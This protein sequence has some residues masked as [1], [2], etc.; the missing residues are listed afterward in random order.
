MKKTQSFIFC[1]FLSL[2][3]FTACT[4]SANQ[5]QK[6]NKS[7]GL[8]LQSLSNKT[9]LVQVSMCHPAFLK[10]IKNKGNDYF[11]YVFNPNEKEEELI[12]SD[13]K[14]LQIETNNNEIHTLYSVKKEFLYE[15]ENKIDSIKFV[16]ISEND[17]EN[18]F[19]VNYK[20]YSNKN[21]CQEVIRLIK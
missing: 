4:L 20:M 14:I 13:P 3:I 6:L 1:F 17:G 12:F 11:K 2:F 18:W 10:Y 16:A 7:L 8:Y 19:F 9:I 15:G 21:I 5:E